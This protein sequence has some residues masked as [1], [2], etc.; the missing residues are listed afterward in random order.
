M[1]E[2]ETIYEAWNEGQDRYS[3]SKAEWAKLM[4]LLYKHC[5]DEEREQILS[6]VLDYGVK[7]EKHAFIEGLKKAFWILFDLLKN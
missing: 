2:L 3:S 4:E 5:S 1:K 7:I 6:I